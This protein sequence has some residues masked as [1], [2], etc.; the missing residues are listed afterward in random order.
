M[1]VTSGKVVDLTQ[2]SDN[3]KGKCCFAAKDVSAPPDQPAWHHQQQLQQSTASLPMP[4]RSANGR[5]LKP[6]LSPC[7]TLLRRLAWVL[8]TVTP[9]SCAWTAPTA[10][11]M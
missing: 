6:L 2:I 11:I 5:K 9:P 10:G 7:C 3:A 8:S 4:H 1:T